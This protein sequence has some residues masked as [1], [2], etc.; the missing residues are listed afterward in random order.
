MNTNLAERAINA[1]SGSVSIDF[2]D[3]LTWAQ[4]C[5]DLAQAVQ[6]D[7]EKKLTELE[8]F[9]ESSSKIESEKLDEC[10][11]KYLP[12]PQDEVPS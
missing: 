12:Q 9:Y 1:I 6:C 4:W 10:R 3:T 8:T 7:N 2:E 5:R 11:K